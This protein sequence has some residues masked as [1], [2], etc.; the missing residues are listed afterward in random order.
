[1][2]GEDQNPT[3]RAKLT[4]NHNVDTDI[5]NNCNPIDG[6]ISTQENQNNNQKR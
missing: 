3:K 1:M 5:V 4:E 2:E 6:K